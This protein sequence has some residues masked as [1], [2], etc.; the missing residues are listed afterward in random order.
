MNPGFV[1]GGV[2][3]AAGAVTAAVVAEGRSR[4]AL[5]GLGRSRGGSRAGSRIRPHFEVRGAGGQTARGYR[6]ENMT[7]KDRLQLMQGMVAADVRDPEM[8]K[9]ALKVTAHCAERDDMC[10][11]KA[12]YGY[13]K[14]N[15]RYTGDIAPHRL[16]PGGPVD[17]VDLYSAGKRTLESGGGDCDDQTIL[18]SSLAILNGIPA[19]FR[20]TASERFGGDNYSHVYPVLGYPKNEPS[21]WI[22]VDATLPGSNNF[23][24]E[25]S[26]A[27]RFEVIA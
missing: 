22:P 21:K 9:L 19:K 25:H 27:K 5:E 3:L 7:I 26:Y 17:S 16:W 13:V 4:Q 1:I 2:L 6:K 10:E 15:V 11:M 12:I 14:K 18:I 8:R 23:G 20:A 24:K